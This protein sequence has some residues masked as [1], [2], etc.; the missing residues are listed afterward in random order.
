MK[1]ADNLEI[2]VVNGRIILKQTLLKEMGCRGCD[3]N[4]LC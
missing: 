3:W 2:A 1:G 4:Y